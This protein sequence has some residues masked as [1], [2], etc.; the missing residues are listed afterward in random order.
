MKKLTGAAAF[1][2][3]LL[4]QG[5]AHAASIDMNDP[6]RAKGREDD[7]RVDVQLINPTLSSGAPIGVNW[8]IQNFSA[9]PVAV[10]TGVIDASYDRDSRTIT[11]AIGSEVPDEGKMP[12]MVVVAPGEKKVFRTAATLTL[13]PAVTRENVGGGPRY[14]RVQVSILRDLQPFAPM[15]EKQ[16]PDTVAQMLSDA[17]FEQWFESTD[18]IYLNAL[19][20]HW[21]ARAS[22]EGSAE[23]RRGRY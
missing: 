5:A 16:T 20:V 22:H 23:Q 12:H 10:A 19:P 14:L 9:D 11:V 18:T 15:I 4:I 3:T 7:V 17:L 21:A 8:Q 13:S 6:H 2:A 1:A